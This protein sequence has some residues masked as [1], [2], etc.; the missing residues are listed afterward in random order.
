MI[1][2]G[3]IYRSK[4]IVSKHVINESHYYNDIKQV[5]SVFVPAEQLNP[6]RNFEN[7][8]MSV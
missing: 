6:Y 3:S 7:D 1:C 2:F 5:Y 8:K 4:K